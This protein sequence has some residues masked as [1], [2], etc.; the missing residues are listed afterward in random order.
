M[1]F[2]MLIASSLNETEVGHDHRQYYGELL[3][4]QRVTADDM[5]KVSLPSVQMVNIGIGGPK[6]EL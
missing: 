2:D 6:A 3:H 4:G 5:K 1:Q